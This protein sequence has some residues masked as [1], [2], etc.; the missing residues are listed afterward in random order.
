VDLYVYVINYELYYLI[1]TM[2]CERSCCFTCFY[3]FL[4]WRFLFH[5]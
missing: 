4:Y 3:M 5:I 2:R 1:V